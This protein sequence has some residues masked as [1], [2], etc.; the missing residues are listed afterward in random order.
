M[1]ARCPAQ[2]RV[3]VKSRFD[4][5]LGQGDVNELLGHALDDPL[6]SVREGAFGGGELGLERRQT[7]VAV[8]QEDVERFGEAGEG[9]LDGAAV[10]L[11][12]VGRE[13]DGRHVHHQGALD[14]LTWAAVERFL[15]HFGELPLPFLLERN[16]V[17]YQS[18]QFVHF[19]SISYKLNQLTF[20]L[21]AF[22]C[23]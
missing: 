5:G 2:V 7:C 20:N 10:E 19:N 17:S 3:N 8:G 6:P 13:E 12:Q 16:L 11:G 23:T 4:V 9:Q 14:L 15:A 18:I 21:I 1:A 22:N